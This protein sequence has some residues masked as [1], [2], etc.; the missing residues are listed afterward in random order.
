MTFNLIDAKLVDLYKDS[1]FDALKIIKGAAISVFRPMQPSDF[2][3][4]Y[5]SISAEQGEF[6]VKIIKENN[7]KNI[8]EFGTSFGISTLF[9]AKAVIETKGIS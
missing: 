5:L 7:L 1:K 3:E 9:L 8:V 2:K 4:A 6:I